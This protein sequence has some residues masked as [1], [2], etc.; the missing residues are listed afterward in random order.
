MENTVIMCADYKIHFKNGDDMF[1][2]YEEDR[3]TSFCAGGFD[4]T[5]NGKSIPFDFDAACS[6]I[7]KDYVHFE[8][9]RGALFNDYSISEDFKEWI[10]ENGT[11]FDSIT[12]EFLSKAT[13]IEEF[14]V[15]FELDNEEWQKGDNLDPDMDF[16]IEILSISFYDENDNEYKVADEVIK[17]FNEGE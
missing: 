9:G 16:T 7:H 3:I 11:P 5:I 1:A 4:F 17:K 8:S 13:S 14:F 6:S 2:L 15:N 10:E 12:A